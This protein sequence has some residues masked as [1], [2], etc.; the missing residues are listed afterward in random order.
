MLGSDGE[1]AVLQIQGDILLLE[2]GQ[3][4]F[5]NIT[6]TGVPDVGAESGQVGVGLTEEITGKVIKGVKQVVVT[7]VKGKHTKHNH[8]LLFYFIFSTLIFY[9]LTF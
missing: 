2:A 8:D 4:G 5:Q 7:A 1:D 3:F 6:V 9:L